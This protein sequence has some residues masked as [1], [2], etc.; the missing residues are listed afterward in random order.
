MR[1]KKAPKPVEKQ[2]KLQD[3]FEKVYLP[4]YMKDK[5]PSYRQVYCRSIERFVAF[6]RG[7]KLISEIES[8]T[9]RA[10]KEWHQDCNRGAPSTAA[11]D[12]IRVRRVIVAAGRCD[13][14][15]RNGRAMPTRS[16][17]MPDNVPLEIEKFFH[18]VYRLQK[19]VSN[20]YAQ[21]VTIALRSLRRFNRKEV[22]FDE[23]PLIINRWIAYLELKLSPR[24][25]KG[26]RATIISLW[27]AASDEGVC[28]P[29]EIRKIRKVKVSR[30]A[31]DAW[32]LEEFQKIVDAAQ[33]FRDHWYRNGINRADWWNAFARVCFDTAL[34][35]GDMLA[36]K[37]SDVETNAEGSFLRT[38][39]SKTGDGIIHRLNPKTA[40]A[41]AKIMT[42]KREV[43]FD[44]PHTVRAFHD[45]W[46]DMLDKAGQDP[47]NRR[48]GVQKIRRTSASLLEAKHPGAATAHLGH[49]CADMARMHYL[50]PKVSRGE[51]PTPPALD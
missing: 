38:V 45:H 41:V 12:V 4:E 48:N 19:N 32:T 33:E 30:P 50:D 46:K 11:A 16:E 42:P 25:V 34:R 37:C 35:R 49:R 5:K 39:Q 14:R 17:S 47:L 9:F 18:K 13:L 2:T 15:P 1:T 3:F 44:F 27:Y 29:P 43:L 23:L 7:D 26:R 21:Q 40:E 28:D 24:T 36:I 51:I 6:L 22:L 20:A 31:P 10:Y 8:A